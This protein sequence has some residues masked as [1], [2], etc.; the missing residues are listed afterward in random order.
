MAN[1]ATTS[2]RTQA[3]WLVLHRGVRIV[4]WRQT[5]T[6]HPLFTFLF[7]PGARANPYPLFEEIRA[8]GRLIADAADARDR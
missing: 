5:R 4:S 8:R 3:R 2:V 1:A 7:A 6:G